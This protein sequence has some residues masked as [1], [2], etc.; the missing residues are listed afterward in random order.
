MR[1]FAFLIFANFKIILVNI[2]QMKVNPEFST[3]NN[4][5]QHSSTV[6]PTC[7]PPNYKQPRH[8][9]FAADPIFSLPEPVLTKA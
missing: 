3:Q 7:Y 9:L 5:K 4:F 2:K 1:L 6:I 8:S